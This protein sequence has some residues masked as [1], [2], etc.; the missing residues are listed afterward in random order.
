MGKMVYVPNALLE[1]LELLKLALRRGKCY[2]ILC[3]DSK[4][5]TEEKESFPPHPLYKE[6]EEKEERLNPNLKEKKSKKNVFF[7]NS[8]A[9]PS[10]EE[11]KQYHEKLAIDCYTAEEFFNYY[12]SFGWCSKEGRLIKNW[13][14][15]MKRWIAN[16]YRFMNGNQQNQQDNALLRKGKR[17]DTATQG[18]GA[19]S[20]QGVDG[21]TG[22]DERTSLLAWMD[23]ELPLLGDD[24][25]DGKAAAESHE[26]DG[27]ASAEGHEDAA[28]AAAEGH[29]GDAEAAA[30]TRKKAIDSYMQRYRVERQGDW[31]DEGVFERTQGW[32][33][34]AQST[35][36]VGVNAVVRVVMMH[37][38]SLAEDMGSTKASR[39]PKTLHRMA[40]ELCRT[41]PYLKMPEV[42]LALNMFRRRKIDVFHGR[43]NTSN[44]MKGMEEFMRGRGKR[45]KELRS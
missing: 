3:Y 16:R 38:Y 30:Q 35:K 29:E 34:L 44:L 6:R 21:G 25:G 5:E 7:P 20:G 43:L 33:T 13:R 22:L 1:D 8:F 4:E 2:D 11:V 42:V 17:R 23:A 28:E 19:E 45:V 9:P 14:A 24:E 10:L 36:Q 39:K 26:R 12:E 15:L 41:Y 40:M 32:L 27:K 18:A 31:A 37:L